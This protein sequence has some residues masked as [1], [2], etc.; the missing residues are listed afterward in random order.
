M[1]ATA[2]TIRVPVRTWLEKAILAS[3]IA[4][5]LTGLWEGFNADAGFYHDHLMGPSATDQIIDGYFGRRPEILVIER[6]LRDLRAITPGPDAVLEVSPEVGLVGH[7]DNEIEHLVSCDVDELLV[8]HPSRREIA[9]ALIV[10]IDLRD[11]IAGG[12]A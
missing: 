1:A 7:L 4:G 10:A 8:E 3:T 5:P 12:D 2:T 6:A 9:E 11:E